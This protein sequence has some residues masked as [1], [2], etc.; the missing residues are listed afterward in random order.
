[1]TFPEKLI[2]NE[3]SC[4]TNGTNELL[5]LICSKEWDSDGSKIKMAVKNNS[6]SF[7]VAP[8]AQF[9]NQLLQRFRRIHD[10]KGYLPVTL[11]PKVT[12]KKLL[13]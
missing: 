1:M 9:S 6:H 2:F 5:D 12:F 10:L 11:L 13:K 4:R 8:S 3:N 7:K